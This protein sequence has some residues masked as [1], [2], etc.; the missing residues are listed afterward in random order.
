MTTATLDARR[1]YDEWVDRVHTRA[2]FRPPGTL[3][4]G[5]KGCLVVPEAGRCELC[6]GMKAR[7]TGEIR[8]WAVQIHEKFGHSGPV[9]SCESPHDVI[10]KAVSW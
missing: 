1:R 4:P 2:H 7:Y 5:D 3:G 6:E 9:E 8:E 10:C